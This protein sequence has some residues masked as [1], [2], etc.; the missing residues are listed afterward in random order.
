MPTRSSEKPL[1]PT[2]AAVRAYYAA[3][4]FLGWGCHVILFNWMQVPNQDMSCAEQAEHDRLIEQFEKQCLE[5][6][7]FDAALCA[8]LGQPWFYEAAV[9]TVCWRRPGDCA[10]LARL[11]SP[12]PCMLP[13]ILCA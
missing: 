12:C 3:L 10:A 1:G 6:T 8:D 13:F 9:V 2:L 5:H 7:K 4:P 11:L